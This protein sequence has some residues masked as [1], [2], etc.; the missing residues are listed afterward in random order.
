MTSDKPREAWIRDSKVDGV[1]YAWINK[2]KMWKNTTHMIEKSAYDKAVEALKRW[3]K[4]INCLGGGNISI[5]NFKS[6]N[7]DMIQTLKELGE[8]DEMS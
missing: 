6:L 2:P 8:L 5:T 3:N 7:D 4:Q 1:G